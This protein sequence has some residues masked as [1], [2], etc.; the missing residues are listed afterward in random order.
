MGEH[1]CDMVDFIFSSVELEPV[2]HVY[3][4]IRHAS[5]EE[6]RALL[7][8]SLSVPSDHVPVV[9]DFA[10]DAA[11]GPSRR[12]P[13]A[14]KRLAGRP[15]M[16]IGAEDAPMELDALAQPLRGHL[17]TQL[18]MLRTLH[19]SLSPLTTTPLLLEA[20]QKKRAAGGMIAEMIGAGANVNACDEEGRS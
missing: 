15:Q 13:M 20:L 5:I 7:L 3:E 19:N 11:Q 1:V 9:V 10:V 12:Q 6:A 18:C 4:P 16:A 2:G 14:L 8:P 17:A